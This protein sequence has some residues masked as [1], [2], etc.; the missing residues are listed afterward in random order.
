MDPSRATYDEISLNMS[1][2]RLS[3]AIACEH[4]T[5]YDIKAGQ[6]LRQRCSSGELPTVVLRS[7][8]ASHSFT[9]DRSP[10][11][12]CDHTTDMPD[13]LELLDQDGEAFAE[14]SNVSTL[15]PV[16]RVL[17]PWTDARLQP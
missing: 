7:R 2:A 13:V 6:L 1:Q 11:A 3:V 10:S 12:A 4:V 8:Y 9:I 16:K 14:F 17:R 15:L 5:Y